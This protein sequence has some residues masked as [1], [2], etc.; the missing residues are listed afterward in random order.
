[1]SLSRYTVI[2]ILLAI[3][4]SIVTSLSSFI[5]F[6]IPLYALGAIIIDGA[7]EALIIPT[8]LTIIIYDSFSPLPFGIVTLLFITMIILIFIFKKIFSFYE[9]TFVP[10]ILIFIGISFIFVSAFSIFTPI[11]YSPIS[12]ASFA[13]QIIFLSIIFFLAKQ[14]QQYSFSG[15]L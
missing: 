13:I 8:L 6:L 11:S 1:M 5:F 2:L 9:G 14:N 10:N 12:I 4:S 3:F 15:T 7:R